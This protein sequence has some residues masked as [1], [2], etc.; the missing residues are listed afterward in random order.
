LN[1]A[2]IGSDTI[3]VY[4]DTSED[5]ANFTSGLWTISDTALD[6]LCA[7]NTDTLGNF[8]GEQN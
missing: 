5:S 4:D 7:R 6:R 1:F 3:A 2:N 8:Y